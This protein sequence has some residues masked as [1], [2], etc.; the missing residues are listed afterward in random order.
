MGNKRK[1][2]PAVFASMIKN[3]TDR[4]VLAAIGLFHLILTY[5]GF[6]GWTCPIFL[7]TGV[8][9]P[10]CGL[11]RAAAALLKGDWK[12]MVKFHAFTPVFLAAVLIAGTV[13][14]VP[15][16][17]RDMIIQRI[18]QIENQTGITLFIIIGLVIYWVV[19]LGLDPA[20]FIALMNTN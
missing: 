12:A 17:W 15:A 4:M 5:L 20:G 14:V 18:K 8:P 19:R 7:A 13:I 1:P 10:G 6:P 3:P 11:S 2:A 16:K 9:C